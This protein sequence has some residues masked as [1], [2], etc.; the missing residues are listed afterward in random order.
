M[1]NSLRHRNSIVLAATLV[2]SVFVAQPAQAQKFKVL[3]TF[4]GAPKDG[5]FPHGVVIRDS[6]GNLY[7]LRSPAVAGNA[8]TPD[9]E[10]RSS[11]TR[12]ASGFGSTVSTA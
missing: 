5:A 6:E 3:H 11:L 12:T 9:A 2:L 8:A 10:P 4:H 7:G 1:D